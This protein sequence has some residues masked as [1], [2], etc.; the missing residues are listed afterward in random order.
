MSERK[1][2]NSPWYLHL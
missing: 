2:Y 1:L